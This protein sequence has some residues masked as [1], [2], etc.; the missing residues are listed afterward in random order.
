MGK[1]QLVIL[2]ILVGLQVVKVLRKK[3]EEAQAG[4]AAEPDLPEET[5]Q[6]PPQP[7]QE[8]RKELPKPTRAAAS[9]SAPPPIAAMEPAAA[10]VQM[11]ARMPTRSES[12]G[13]QGA[14]RLRRLS[15]RDAVLGKILLDPPPG[16]RFLDGIKPSRR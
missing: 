9:L 8:D 5:W 7:V 11:E 10:I 13:N 4:P 1:L 3:Y 6:E 15:M 14:G 12:G 16:A 2:A